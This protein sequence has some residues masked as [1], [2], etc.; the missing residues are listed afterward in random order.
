VN[1]IGEERPRRDSVDTLIVIAIDCGEEGPDQFVVT[2]RAA[3]CV[4]TVQ[5]GRH[6]SSA[7]SH[8]QAPVIM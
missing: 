7:C 8:H 4:K 2:L 1:V 3:R 6:R 5:A